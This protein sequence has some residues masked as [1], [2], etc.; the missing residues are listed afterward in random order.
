MS[1]VQCCTV[2]VLYNVLITHCVCH[3]TLC[4]VNSVRQFVYCTMCLLHIV[5]AIVRYIW[6]TVLDSLCIVQCAYYTLCVP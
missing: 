3:S 5:C 1:G 4:L 2:C 6:C